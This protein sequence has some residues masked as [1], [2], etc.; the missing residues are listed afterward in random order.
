MDQQMA[1]E[2]INITES[3]STHYGNLITIFTASVTTLAGIAGSAGVC[4]IQFPS[5]QMQ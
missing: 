1:E 4:S 2:Q 3:L 5:L